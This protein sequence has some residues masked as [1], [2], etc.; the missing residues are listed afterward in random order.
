MA[1]NSSG[2]LSMGGSTAGQS[3]NLEL[4]YGST[5]TISLNDTAVRNLAGIASGSISL[6]SFYGKSSWT[7]S[8]PNPAIFYGGDSYSFQSKSFTFY[9]STYRVDSNGAQ[10]GSST[11]IGT[12]RS[13]LLGAGLGNLACFYGGINGSPNNKLTRI[14]INGS[15]VGSEDS[16][17]TTNYGSF[18][19]KNGYVSAGLKTTYF[20]WAYATNNNINDLTQSF[21]N[22]S[23]R[24]NSSGALIGSEITINYDFLYG[25]MTVAGSQGILLGARRNS[26]VWQQLYFVDDNGTVTGGT[27]TAAGTQRYLSHGL[28]SGTDDTAIFY[29]GIITSTGT[30]CAYC[31]RYN[32]NGAMIGS[33]TTIPW[34][35]GGSDG[36]QLPA[37]A[38]FTN[39]G[40]Y[41]S[42]QNTKRIDKTGAAVG[43]LTSI[44][45]ILLQELGGSN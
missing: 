4:G 17:G 36:P 9:N 45:S 24:L 6:S 29:A 22:K 35:V 39:L 42:I 8:K 37:G 21:L 5:A 27:T 25:S 14:D 11:N 3:I 40:M 18:T 43:S 31:D 33:E 41:Y 10:I 16:V 13:L 19:N 34:T 28:G 26:N 1:L 32:S 12:A 2:T 38:S 20:Y 30:S 44:T 15:Q 23:I 7:F